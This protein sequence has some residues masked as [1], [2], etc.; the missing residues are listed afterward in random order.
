MNSDIDLSRHVLETAALSGVTIPA[1]DLPAVAG[2][3]ANLARVAGPLL[4]FSI[5]EET[6]A[7]PVYTA[8]EGTPE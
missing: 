2:V 8:F 4:A 1:G 6:I 3:F 7:A 5:P